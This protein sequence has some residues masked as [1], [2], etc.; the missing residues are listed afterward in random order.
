M[1]SVAKSLWIGFGAF[2]GANARFWLGELIGHR[3]FPWATLTINV[4]GSLAIG[5]FYAWELRQAPH[6]A[7]RLFFAVGICGG[8]TTFSAFSW[9]TLRLLEKGDWVAG[10]A[11]VL[12]SIFMTILACAGGF[13][14]TRSILGG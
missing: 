4:I 5:I 7:F 6:S 10:G 9:E 1:E 12:A 2:I 13:Y 3:A 14:L 11:Y 8:F